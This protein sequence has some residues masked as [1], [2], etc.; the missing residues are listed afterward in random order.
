MTGCGGKIEFHNLKDVSRVKIVTTVKYQPVAGRPCGWRRWFG[1]ST[2]TTWCGLW[3][4]PA[5]RHWRVERPT[6]AQTSWTASVRA[7]EIDRRSTV[8]P[9]SR[10]STQSSRSRR[11]RHRSRTGV[12]VAADRRRSGILH[13]DRNS[14][15]A[16]RASHRPPPSTVR[17]R[18]RKAAEETAGCAATR[19]WRWFER[20]L[21]PRSR[22]GGQNTLTW[23]RVSIKYP[24]INR[25]TFINS[26]P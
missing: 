23:C 13:I 3:R 4:I 24:A 17:C 12:F 5:P 21:R 9:A 1:G 20:F 11:R 22:P 18:P 6:P 14:A 8:S 26:R 16:T 10:P 25:C 15:E 19:S 2:S 7:P